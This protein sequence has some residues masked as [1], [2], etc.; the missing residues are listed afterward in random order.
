MISI[1][2]EIKTKCG[3]CGNPLLINALVNDVFCSK[4]QKTNKLSNDLWYSILDDAVKE[5]P[6]MDMNQAQT[7]TSFMGEYT[8]N[9]LYG[10]QDARCDECKTVID[11]NAIKIITNKST[12]EC[13]KCKSMIQLRPAPEFVNKKFPSAKWVVGEDSNLIITGKK[14][15]KI[16]EAAKPVLFTC[17]SCA[18][19]LEIDGTDR[20][21]ICEFCDSQIYL[22]DDL[23]FRLHPAKMIDR[24]YLCLDESVIEEKIPYWYHIADVTVDRAGNLCVASADDGEEDFIVWSLGPD[25]KTRWTRKGLKYHYDDTGITIAGSDSLYL[26]NKDK[27]SLLKLSSNDGSTIDKLKG[28]KKTEVE[29]YPFNMM[30]CDGLICDTDDTI[31]TLINDKIVRFNPDGSRAS[32]WHETTKSPEDVKIKGKGFFEKLVGAFRRDDSKINIY[33]KYSSSS[34]DVNELGDKPQN[35]DSDY[36]RIN[37]GW[38]GYLYIMG[39]SSNDGELAKYDRSGKKIWSVVV[40]LQSKDCKPCTD[41]KGNVYIVGEKE[42]G[43]TNL[44]KFSQVTKT[45]ETV[46]TD[47]LE[48]G[49]LK[50]EEHLAVSPDGTIFLL[51]YYH[52]LKIFTADGSLKYITEQSKEEDKEA[53]DELKESKEKD[54][55]F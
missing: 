23:W 48:G 35:I 4:C 44:I 32:L 43:H 38:D 49:V 42:G 19:N 55:R 51:D 13:K 18:G 52:K 24:W 15:H 11:I 5:V 28:K 41:S 50:G 40:P 31:L 9:L 54:E 14:K 39:R 2:F 22:P 6:D 7:S 34:P 47:V 33:E 3:Y 10:K 20:M 53:L 12:Y 8:F 46:L 45:F 26:W 27:H 17:P 1:C 25:L 16:P 21:V 37:L 30:G 36:T 29:P